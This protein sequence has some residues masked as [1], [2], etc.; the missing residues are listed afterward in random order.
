MNQAWLCIPTNPA[1]G[2]QGQGD[3][4]LKQSSGTQKSEANL[5][6]MCVRLP[7]FSICN[8]TAIDPNTAHRSKVS[9]ARSF[10]MFVDVPL[11]REHVADS[12]AQ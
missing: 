5:E 10:K 3:H 7:E 1:L 4:K 8:S 6:Y 2:R 12:Q 11:H 9:S